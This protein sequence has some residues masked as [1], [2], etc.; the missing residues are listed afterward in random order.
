MP[1]K[2]IDHEPSVLRIEGLSEPGK[3]LGEPK[4]QPPQPDVFVDDFTGEPIPVVRPEP[5]PEPPRPIAPDHRELKRK[6]DQRARDEQLSLLVRLG[7]VDVADPIPPEPPKPK[8]V[9]LAHNQ[10]LLGD[11]L[12][13]TF[14]NPNALKRRI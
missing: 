8:P 5:Q 2:P 1:R 6:A 4:P 12:V 10:R 14:H 11:K 9:Q 13:I 7:L 3:L